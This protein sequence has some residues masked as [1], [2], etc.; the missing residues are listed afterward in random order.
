MLDFLQGLL[1]RLKQFSQSLDQTEMFVDKPWVLLDEDGQQQMYIF[2]RNG[3]LLMSLDGQVQV[4]KWDYI[5]A[6]QS[7]LIDRGVDKL[8][9]NHFFFTDALL[10]LARDGRAESKFVLANR[11]LIPDLN[12]AN[13]LERLGAGLG[14]PKALHQVNQVYIVTNTNSI[15]VDFLGLNTLPVK[16]DSIFL[17][18]G[19]APNGRFVSKHG[20]AVYLDGGVVKEIVWPKTYVTRKGQALTVDCKV[21]DGPNE[22]KDKVFS[23]NGQPLPDGEYQPPGR[24]KFRVV[25][26]GIDKFLLF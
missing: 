11:Q 8:L 25:N 12:V 26:G 13:Y 22:I 2:R 3:E 20:W 1:P 23:V 10:V 24:R 16:G 18:G 17:N 15:E 4:G 14:S 19:S 21:K 6:A 5:A 9:L 7:L